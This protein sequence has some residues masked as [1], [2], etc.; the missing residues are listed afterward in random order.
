[1]DSLPSKVMEHEARIK[2]AEHR[3]KDLETE[4]HDLRELTKAVAVTN[5]NVKQLS[6]QFEELHQDVKELKEIPSNRWEKI[7]TA[8]ITGVVCALIGAILALVIK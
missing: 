8:I 7:I 5:A 3:L 2:G 6:G 1:M 4:V